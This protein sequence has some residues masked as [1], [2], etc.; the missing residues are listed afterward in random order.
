MPDP[1]RPSP[2]SHN[3]RPWVVAAAV[4][5]STSGL[6]V[7]S[8]MFLDWSSDVRGVRL[9][10][11]RALF[12]G[13]LLIPAV[14]RPR[15]RWLMLPMVFCFAGMNMSYLSAMT[16][17]TAANAIWLQYTAPLWV[18]I[19]GTLVLKEPFTRRNAVSAVFLI[20]GLLTILLPELGG[21]NPVGV[22]LALV[23][24]GF[25]AAVVLFLRTMRDE[26]GPWLVVLNHLGAAMI[27]APFMFAHGFVW[28]SSPQF[29]ILVL[30]G[31]FQ[32]GLAYFCFSRGLRNVT[33]SEAAILG[34][35][36]PLL[37]PVWAYLVA[38]ELPGTTTALGAGLILLG[39]LYQVAFQTRANEQGAR[40]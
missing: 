20:L 9:A 39:L 8:T 16:L 34:L 23:A 27:I 14:R 10:F 31:F 5:W 32:M 36:E 15:L 22:V 35:V 33:G 40:E 1:H 17:G 21:Q 24:G 3:G 37:V 30:F 19:Y 13:L 26:D 29:G 2:V 12:A 28:P 18:M 4:L 7:K 38:T 6:F 25:Y 11:W